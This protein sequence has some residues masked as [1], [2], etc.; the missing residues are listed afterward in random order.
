[1]VLPFQE[2]QN[3]LSIFQEDTDITSPK[4][5]YTMAAKLGFQ[6]KNP[7]FCEIRYTCP[8]NTDE[9]AKIVA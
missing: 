8:L 6:V 7:M 4:F 5:E 9:I 2:T 3:I 1:M